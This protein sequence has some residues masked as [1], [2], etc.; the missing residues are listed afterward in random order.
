MR[1][2]DVMGALVAAA[3]AVGYLIELD[4]RQMAALRD[5][6]TASAS[7]RETARAFLKQCGRAANAVACRQSWGVK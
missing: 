5:P 6:V 1:R 2:R 4:Q 7:A 3:I